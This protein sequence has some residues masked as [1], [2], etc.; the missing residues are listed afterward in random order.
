MGLKNTYDSTYT[1]HSENLY[2]CLNVDKSYG[3]TYIEEGEGIVDS[4][5]LASSRNITDSIGG[6]NLRSVS[7][8]FFGEK[9]SGEE[10]KNKLKEIDFGS[11]KT[12]DELLE[13]F[14]EIKKNSIVRSTKQI[15]CINCVGDHLENAKDCYYVFDGFDLEKYAIVLGFFQVKIYQ[16]ALEW[17]VVN[18]FMKQ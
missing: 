7:N 17:V 8:Y 12:R 6:V 9:L 5:Y 16:T 1:H 15:N 18:L 13:S 3:N 2:E 11:R 4:N 14:K 10:Y